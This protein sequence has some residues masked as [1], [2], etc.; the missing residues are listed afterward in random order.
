MHTTRSI[1]FLATSAPPR[2]FR[3]VVLF[4]RARAM[5]DASAAKIALRLLA[6]RP[7]RVPYLDVKSVFCVFGLGLD[8]CVFVCICLLQRGGDALTDSRLSRRRNALTWLSRTHVSRVQIRGRDH[9]PRTNP[10]S[11][12]VTQRRVRMTSAARHRNRQTS[13]HT[14]G[15]SVAHAILSCAPSTVRPS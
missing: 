3:Q 13:S 1:I 12:E 15:R 8:T 4:S 7:R 2:P 10:S 14:Y 11:P 5:L 9:H 6:I